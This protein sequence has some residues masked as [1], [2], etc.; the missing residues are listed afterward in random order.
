[1]KFRTLFLIFASIVGINVRADLPSYSFFKRA[2]GEWAGHGVVENSKAGMKFRSTGSGRVRFSNNLKTVK[3]HGEI[4]RQNTQQT[5]EYTL[6]FVEEDGEIVASLRSD[7]DFDADFI[8]KVAADGTFIYGIHT[9]EKTGLT[10]ASKAFFRNEALIV[11]TEVT[12]MGMVMM[13]SRDI[14]RKN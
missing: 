8:V 1:M 10:I 13:T 5:Y 11:E 4:Q 3:L 7:V 14:Y 6:K 9:D 12:M 2:V